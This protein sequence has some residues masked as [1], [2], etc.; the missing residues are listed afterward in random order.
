[1]QPAGEGE[2][3]PADAPGSIRR[4]HQA[5]QRAAF[6]ELFFDLAYIFAFAQ[7]S[8][9][10]IGH[11]DWPGAGRTLVLLLPLW[12]VWTGTS[13]ITDT[14]DPDRSTVQLHVI[15][16]MV[17][18]LVMAVAVPHAYDTT[19]GVFAGVYVVVQVGAAVYY[20]VIT[21]HGPDQRPNVRALFWS[22]VSAVPWIAGSFASGT[23]GE[24]LW[25][26]AAVVDYVAPRLRWPTPFMGRMWPDEFRPAGEHVS[27]R[28]RQFFIIALGETILT[29]GLALSH[30][31]FS[32]ART[33]AFLI[34]FATTALMARIYIYR[35]GEL[36][37]AVITRAPEPLR[38]GQRAAFA[39]LVMAAGVVLVAAGDEVVIAHP[40]G[41]P[42]ATWV[43][44]ILSGPATF[45]AGRA[46]LDQTVFAR[47]SWSRVSG[48]AALAVVSPAMLFAPPLVAAG[49]GTLALFGVVVSNLASWRHSG[50]PPVVG[51]D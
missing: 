43:A 46:G 19:R 15:L 8:N 34:A 45:L 48:L 35:A 31:G 50:G 4:S 16:V 51:E 42:R 36:M 13:W 17:G 5:P 39:H 6:L 24:G 12:W 10:L 28:Y 27:E 38:P 47:V 21:R 40:L 11:L 41:H 25:A 32:A 18:I 49:A 14:F 29:S 1:M 33:A 23:V 20:V 2:T 7:L 3:V 30:S 9:Y 37:E 44:L 22:S 26:F